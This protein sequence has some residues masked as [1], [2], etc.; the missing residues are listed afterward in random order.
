MAI[1]LNSRLRLLV[2]DGT[3]NILEGMGQVCL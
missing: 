3:V 2:Q 1:P